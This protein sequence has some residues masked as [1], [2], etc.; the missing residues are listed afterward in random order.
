MD[1]ASVKPQFA[2]VR[3]LTD[4]CR[5]QVCGQALHTLNMTWRYTH[6]NIHLRHTFGIPRISQQHE[7]QLSRRCIE[8]EESWLTFIVYETHRRLRFNSNLFSFH[9]S[10][11][12]S[13]AN[14][15]HLTSCFF[16]FFFLVKADEFSDDDDAVVVDDERIKR[17][18]RQDLNNSL[19]SGI[20]N[21]K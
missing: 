7:N 3:M 20:R 1:S 4:I 17:H 6:I 9:L 11:L 10:Y 8:F 15:C 13:T 12:K 18:S 19:L 21:E 16:L 5:L 2:T 14:Q